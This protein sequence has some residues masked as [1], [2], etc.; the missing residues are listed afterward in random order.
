MKCDE[1]RNRLDDFVDGA[2]AVTEAR[3]VTEHLQGCVSCRAEVAALR[4]LLADARVLPGGIEPARDLWPAIEQEIG[5]GNLRRGR[6]GAWPARVPGGHRLLA[7]AAVL[8]AVIG[9]AVGLLVLRETGGGP[10]L[11]GTVDGGT[12][13][14]A[15]APAAAQDPAAEFARARAE[16]RAALEARR[17]ELSPATAAVIDR[18]LAVIERAAAE[19]E[20][21][22]ADDPGNQH[23]RGLLLAVYRQEIELLLR[24]A[25][26]PAAS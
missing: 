17:A 16:L 24:A 20:T 13:G 1:I 6:F 8:V 22:M 26:L 9:T 5:A 21:A 7:A 15:L 25:K 11:P 23:L 3:A 12:V 14:L 10:A 4:R 19:I 18:N 2:L